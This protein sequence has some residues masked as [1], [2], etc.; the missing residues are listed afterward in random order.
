MS[1]IP[2]MIH[3]WDKHE[4][5]TL[6]GKIRRLERGSKCNNKA[7]LKLQEKK[8]ILSCKSNIPVKPG[9]AG[10]WKA[11]CQGYGASLDK[12][13]KKLPFKKT[14]KFFKAAQILTQI[15]V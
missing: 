5:D 3:C 2:G 7:D 10:S 14:F 9:E 13:P 11:I 1:F 4:F 8:K 12:D 15:I 6:L